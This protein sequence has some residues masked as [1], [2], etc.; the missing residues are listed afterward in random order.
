MKREKMAKKEAK[1]RDELNNKQQLKNKQPADKG[2]AGASKEKK[3]TKEDKMAAADML[4]A[5][6]NIPPELKEIIDD[7]DD[8]LPLRFNDPEE[9]MEI[10]STLEEKNLF[11]IKRCQDSEQQLESQKQHEKEMKERMNKQINILKGNE[12]TNMNRINKVILEKD[13]LVGITEDSEGKS[14]DPVTQ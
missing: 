2:K 5:D 6:L 1:R 7:S 8:D 10:F 11:L 13:A 12:S 9:L 3:A 14:L 4:E